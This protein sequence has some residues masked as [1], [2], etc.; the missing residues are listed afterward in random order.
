MDMIKNVSISA[1][2]V[3]LMFQP[4]Y[5]AALVLTS[6]LII[7]SGM[8]LRRIARFV[9]AIKGTYQP[10]ESPPN[11]PLALTPPVV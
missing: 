10:A 8:P 5:R 2:S 11:V 9:S 7:G 4:V 3:A 6:Q 1:R